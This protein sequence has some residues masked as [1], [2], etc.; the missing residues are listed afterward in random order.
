MEHYKLAEV[1]GVWNFWLR[2][3]SCFGWIYAESDTF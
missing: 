2:L 1:Y 3:R